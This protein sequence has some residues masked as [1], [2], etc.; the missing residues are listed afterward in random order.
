MP[1]EFVTLNLTTEL[2]KKQMQD[3]LFEAVKELMSD[4]VLP[5]A[6]NRAHRSDKLKEGET[7]H[8]ADSLAVR[9]RR[10]KSGVKATLYSQSGH[11]GYEEIGTV[12]EDPH[13][14][15][16]PAFLGH[17]NET[18]GKVSEKIKAIPPKKGEVKK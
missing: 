7:I 11:G 15:M 17:V 5:D 8:N 12:K 13:P 1:D 10:I 16:M 2:A 6:K 4:E 14:Y 3:S 9:V 18:Y